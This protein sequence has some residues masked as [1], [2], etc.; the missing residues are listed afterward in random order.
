MYNCSPCILSSTDV[1]HMFLSGSRILI[2]INRLFRSMSVRRSDVPDF[3]TTP[4]PTYNKFKKRTEKQFLDIGQGD[5]HF[6]TYSL[7]IPDSSIMSGFFLGGGCHSISIETPT[8]K[9]I[10][11]ETLYKVLF[12][13]EAINYCCTYRNFVDSQGLL[14]TLI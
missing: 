4:V 1:Y 8:N 6:H 14:K 7:L 11:A 12:Y 10:Q 5:R 3:Q 2:L 9:F 13:M